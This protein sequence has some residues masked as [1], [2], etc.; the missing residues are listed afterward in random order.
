MNSLGTQIHI[1][2]LHLEIIKV[3]YT[4]KIMMSNSLSSGVEP[5]TQSMPRTRAVSAHQLLQWRR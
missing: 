5:V 3:Y 4:N 1:T 2:Y